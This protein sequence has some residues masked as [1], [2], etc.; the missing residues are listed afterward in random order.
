MRNV[1]REIN[2][3]LSILFFKMFVEGADIILSGNEKSTSAEL[4]AFLF[5]YVFTVAF[6][7]IYINVK[8]TDLDF[9]SPSQVNT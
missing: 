8:K 2:K 6:G 4:H 9:C 3:F 7:V 5:V 1:S